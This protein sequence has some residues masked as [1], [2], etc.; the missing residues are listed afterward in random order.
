MR[1]HNCVHNKQCI[2]IQHTL[3]SLGQG[4]VYC[5]L[6]STDRLMVIIQFWPSPDY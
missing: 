2:Y 3:D 5:V 4:S 1:K 6:L